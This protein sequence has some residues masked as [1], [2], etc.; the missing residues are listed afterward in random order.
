MGVKTIKNGSKKKPEMGVKEAQN[1]S[2]K[3]R[4]GSKKRSPKWE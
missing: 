3:R 2:K 1:G 4:Y